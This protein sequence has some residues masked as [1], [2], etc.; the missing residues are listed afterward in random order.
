VPI[1]EDSEEAI[2]AFQKTGSSVVKG[3]QG[4][5]PMR[6]GPLQQASF[7]PVGRQVP[8]E[9]DGGEAIFAVPKT[10]SL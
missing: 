5:F 9:E 7:T 10:G 6:S 1:D 8:I 4:D 2:L 3:A